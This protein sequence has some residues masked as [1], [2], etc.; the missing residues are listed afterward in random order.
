MKTR[1]T[2]LT[3]AAQAHNERIVAKA[4][5]SAAKRQE[6]SV[7]EIAGKILGLE[8][9]ETRRSDGLD[10]H[11]LAVWQIKKALEEAYKAGFEAG[12]K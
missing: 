1:N 6:D 12:Q 10:F 8:T 11:D 7:Q 5:N 9:L 4:R 2:N 3:P